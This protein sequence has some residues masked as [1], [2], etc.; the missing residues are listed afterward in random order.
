M[1]TFAGRFLGCTAVAAVAVLYVESN[2]WL[3]DE[4]PPWVRHSTAVGQQRHV[5]LQ[6]GSHV[7]LN[8]ATELRVRIGSDR[9]EAVLARGEVRFRVESAGNAPLLVLAVGTK[10]EATRAQFSERLV[11]TSQVDVLVEK[12]Q[13]DISVPSVRAPLTVVAGESISLKSNAVYTRKVLSPAAIERKTAWTDGWIS[14]LKAPLPEAVTEFNRYHEQQLV[15]VDPRLAGLEIGGRFRS[16]DLN[17]F[18]ATLEHSFDVQAKS[19][20]VQGTVGDTIYLSGRC[21]RAP[22]Q[23]N[24]PLVQ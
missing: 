11:N 4:H 12:G 18:I 9:R 24:W 6:D 19:A 5:V 23:C 8:T 15:L 17:S 20:V 7:D 3:S 13:V 1:F 14:F 10:L 21:F 2:G 16:S 22:Q